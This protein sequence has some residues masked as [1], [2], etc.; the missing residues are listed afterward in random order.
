M[1]SETVKHQPNRFATLNLTNSKDIT[2]LL[3]YVHNEAQSIKPEGVTVFDFYSMDDLNHA[4]KWEY[5]PFDYRVNPYGFRME[6]LPKEVDIAVFG[7][8]FT[9]GIGMPEHLLWHSLLAKDL[10][11]SCANFG[12]AGASVKTIIDTFLIVSKHVKIKK[13]IF[14]FPPFMRFQVAKTNVEGVTSH[15]D[16]IPGHKSQLCRRYGIDGDMVYKTLP[17][18]ELF[19]VAKDSLYLAEYI[20]KDR[21]IEIFYSCWEDESWYFIENMKFEYAK[22][23][24]RWMTPDDCHGDL[25]RDRMHPGPKH[26]K[27]WSLS[28]NRFLK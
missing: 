27:Y 19:K 20:A 7:C 5:E 28:I 11:V 15:F 3:H 1:N 9:F 23:L 17:N 26:H 2:D 8:S 12:I 14:L 13:A 24:P 18:E 21:D 10:K 25:A 4:D 22:L 16:V 6:E